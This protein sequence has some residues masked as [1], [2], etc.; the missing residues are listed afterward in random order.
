MQ[1]N[2]VLANYLETGELADDTVRQLIQT[3]TVF[4]VF[5]LAQR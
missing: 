5:F 1:D 2:D 3:R 4:P